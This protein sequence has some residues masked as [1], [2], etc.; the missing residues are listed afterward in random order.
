MD[1]LTNVFG[2][3]AQFNK[4]NKQNALPLYIVE[5]YE[6]SEATLNDCRCIFLTP[7]GELVTLPALKK[8]IK[9]IQEI[10]NVPVVLKLSA[11]S[12]YRRNKMIENKISFI[13]NKQI[14]LPFMGTFLT[15]EDEE[16]KEITKFMFSTQQLVLLYLYA[17]T[18]KLY[19][20]EATKIL[21]F[22]AM[23]M[24][25]AVKQLETVG[26]FRIVKVGVNKIIESDYDSQKLYERVKG[27][28]SSPVRKTGYL[29]KTEITAEMVIAGETALAEDTMLNPS[30]VTTY[31]VFAKNFNKHLMNELVE[32]DEQVKV[33]LW[34]YEPRQFSDNG[35]A[36]KLSVALS[37]AENDDERIEEAVEELLEGVWTD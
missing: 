21:P 12:F 11:I 37:F 32:P 4:W 9:K 33:E 3:Q 25:R 35:M 16:A 24:S 7:K 17:K 22:T 10:D 1:L 5:S 23:T 6:F 30:R 8:Q 14:F 29:K 36:D 2:I 20:S 28:L 18:K 15:R 13:T 27:Y 34:E 31:A 19:I 26:L